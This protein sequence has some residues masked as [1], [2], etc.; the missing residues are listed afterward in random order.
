MPIFRSIKLQ[1]GMNVALKY[2]MIMWTGI[3]CTRLVGF[4]VSPVSKKCRVFLDLVSECQR[5]D[6]A[7]NPAV[8]WVRLCLSLDSSW[9][10]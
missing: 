7:R 3:D 1:D 4:S 2:G 5:I 10:P 9:Q 8:G 6:R